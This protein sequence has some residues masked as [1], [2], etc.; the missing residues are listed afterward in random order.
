MR[1][2][3]QLPINT[4]AP[5]IPYL[6]K[7]ERGADMQTLQSI[8]INVQYPFF[9]LTKTGEFWENEY[10]QHLS[11]THLNRS[12]LR[13]KM[14]A[15]LQSKTNK[16]KEYIAQTDEQKFME[17][18]IM[19]FEEGVF[20]V[21]SDDVPFVP[22]S[23]LSEQ[24]RTPLSNI[25]AL[26]PMLAAKTDESALP[27]LNNVYENSYQL[28]RLSNNFETLS[29]LEERQY[30]LQ[31]IDIISL[32]QAIMD[33]VISTCKNQNIP[34]QFT[35]SVKEP[36]FVHLNKQIYTQAL[37]N[38]VRN[39]L[40]YTQDS[41]QI[42]VS[43]AVQKNKVVIQ[44][45]DKG[46]GINSAYLSDV[47]EPFYSVNP[48]GDEM[49]KPGMGIGLTIVQKAV[50]AFGGMATI[51]SIFGEFTKVTMSMPISTQHPTTL[52]SHPTDYLLNRF[53][54]LYIQLE[55]FCQLPYLG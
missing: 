39:S 34:I 54:P 46:I 21:L 27:Y 9:I 32:T 14:F 40:E 51:Q 29:R 18:I 17:F 43:L 19:S 37:L 20:A 55:G 13:K 7:R 38:L 16:V 47:F 11:S 22:I 48:Y 52:N 1:N 6:Y 28:L 50:Q 30:E 12:E 2:M 3:I 53:S 41:N 15:A 26:L 10:A 5:S 25:F 24:M 33:S 44:I 35:T 36:V 23:G 42:H 49:L 8:F 4:L 45:A 31:S